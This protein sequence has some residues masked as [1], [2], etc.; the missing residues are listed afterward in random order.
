MSTGSKDAERRETLR[1]M[2]VE[3]DRIIL[4]MDEHPSYYKSTID[5]ISDARKLVR[6]NPKK[7]AEKVKE[8]LAAA[9]FE[10]GI[11]MDYHRVVD[12]IAPDDP[13][14]NEDKVKSRMDDYH[15]EIRKGDVKGAEKAVAA[16]DK[17]IGGR[18]RPPAIS[19]RIE[20]ERISRAD[21]TVRLIVSNVDKADVILNSVYASASVWSE[22]V[23]LTVPVIRAGDSAQVSIVLG[24]GA[25]D[26]NVIHV[27]IT[28]TRDLVPVSQRY[29]FKIFVE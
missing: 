10:A 15:S 18:G 11:A 21:M 24:D 29:S 26:A 19:V 27:R 17:A 20:S 7:S 4:V 13:I 2:D 1:E 5:T 22:D 8:A 3:L 16:L 12:G 9:E 6:D 28:Y 14:F 25:A 23:L